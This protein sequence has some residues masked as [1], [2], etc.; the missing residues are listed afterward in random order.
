VPGGK[1][2]LDQSHRL[3]RQ[4]NQHRIRLRNGSI[5]HHF[6]ITRAS[7]F[8][9]GINLRESQSIRQRRGDDVARKKTFLNVARLRRQGVAFGTSMRRLLA[10]SAIAAI[11]AGV[12][13]PLAVALGTSSTPACCLPSGKHHCSQHSS[14]PGFSSKSDQCPYSSDVVVSGFQGLEAVNF[15]LAAPQVARNFGPIAV[16]GAYRVAFRELPGRGPPAFPL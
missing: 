9:P 13:S 12:V 2:G 7:S 1:K 16:S 14:G 15:A 4:A 5:S 10:G 11:L 8:K 6:P 3:A